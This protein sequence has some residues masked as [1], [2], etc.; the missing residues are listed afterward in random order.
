MR[1][2]AGL[3][4][5]R[6]V[7]APS[8]QVR[9][10]QDRVREALFSMLGPTLPE[11]RVLDLF[12]GAGTL[13]LE[14]W[15]RGAA[16]VCWVEQHAGTAKKLEKTVRSLCVAPEGGATRVVCSD[17]HRYVAAVPDEYDLVL[18]DPPYDR[19]NQFNHLEKLLQAL[20]QG[21]GLR[22]GGL[23]VYEQSSKSPPLEGMGFELL[24]DRNYGAARILIY[25]KNTSP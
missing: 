20:G 16:S 10:T 25:R 15:S 4:G 12:A 6:K 5:G 9:P 3:L 19:E 24:R 18:A 1:V 22:S 7:L 21:G 11:A 2:T 14:A 8:E 23:F 17:A 13:G